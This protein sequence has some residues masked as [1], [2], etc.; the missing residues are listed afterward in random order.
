MSRGPPPYRTWAPIFQ[1][2]EGSCANAGVAFR[3]HDLLD[4]L[5]DD[6]YVRLERKS[7]KPAI[8]RAAV[9]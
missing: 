1:R 9:R 8:V 7:E 2:I 5:G 4:L 6:A 3:D